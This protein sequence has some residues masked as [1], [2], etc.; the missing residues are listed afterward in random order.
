MENIENK[1]ISKPKDEKP[2]EK[3]CEDLYKDIMWLTG[4]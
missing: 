3:T 1:T 2:E 4:C